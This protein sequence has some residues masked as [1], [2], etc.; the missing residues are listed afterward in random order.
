MQFLT[1]ATENSHHL[2]SEVQPK[3]LTVS[4]CFRKKLLSKLTGLRFFF[5]N[6]SLKDWQILGNSQRSIFYE[7]NSFWPVKM[8][9]AINNFLW[10]AFHSGAL[11]GQRGGFTKIKKINKLTYLG[12]I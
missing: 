6:E 2:F 1:K 7:E 9:S 5:L 8:W 11:M 3:L 12:L 4:I 10:Q